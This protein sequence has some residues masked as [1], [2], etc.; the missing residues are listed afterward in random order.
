MS[1]PE[2]SLAA[3]IAIIVFMLCIG[4]GLGFGWAAG[5]WLLNA[6]VGL[7]RKNR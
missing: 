6:I 1:V 5:H 3:S 7:F 4:L 2:L